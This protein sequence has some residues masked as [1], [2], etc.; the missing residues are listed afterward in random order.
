M[1]TGKGVLDALLLGC[2]PV[3]FHVGQLQQWRW[4]WGESSTDPV[5][6]AAQAA[7]A[8]R[9]AV[10]SAAVN[11]AAARET[12]YRIVEVI[13]IIFIAKKLIIVFLIIQIIIPINFI[14]YPF[15]FSYN[16]IFC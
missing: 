15:C 5:T 7:V 14:D 4:H 16:I 6:T 8:A 12:R 3:L 10:A 9:S 1:R 11:A 13:A 2:V